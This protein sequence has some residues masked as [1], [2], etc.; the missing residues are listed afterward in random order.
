[1][2]T[3][4]R[5]EL[6]DSGDYTAAFGLLA[7]AGFRLE[8]VPAPVAPG[9]LPA[10]VALDRLAETAAVTRAVFDAL[11]GAGLAPVGVAAT[12]AAAV[13]AACGRAALARA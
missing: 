11:H 6:R 10:A 1:M 3:F 5:F 8:R 4:V 7:G 2:W 9:P 12:H 13:R